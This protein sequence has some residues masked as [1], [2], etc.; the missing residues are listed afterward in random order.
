MDRILHHA[1]HTVHTSKSARDA[2]GHGTWQSKLNEALNSSKVHTIL[3]VLLIC[4]LMTVIIGMLLEQYYS[5]SQVQGLT[6]AFKD[7]LEK[8][9]LCPDPS[10]LAHYG[11]H[12]LHE[13][14]ERMEYASLAIL[15][16]FL[17]ENMLLVLANG[18]RFFANPFHILDIV[19]VVVSVGFELQG[20]LGE[21]H[22]AGIG[23]VVFAR[24]WR[25]IRLG[26]GIHEMH[27]EHEAED[28]GEHR[29]SD[30]AGSLEAP[31]QKGSFEQHA[32]GTSGV[33]HARSQASSNR[34][35]RE[36]CCV[37]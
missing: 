22:D 14:A 7:C 31:L 30:A 25:F 27:E 16:I 11:N 34:E 15:L 36:G 13:W 9:T 20:I 29:V 8:R 2:E 17:L 1:V 24:T 37:Q 23:L 5:D 19:V 35:G 28:H 26:H 32:K 4:D 33:H 12:D 18:C 6:E 10:H 21:G 3:N